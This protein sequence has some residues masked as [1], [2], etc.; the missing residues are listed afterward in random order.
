MQA[1]VGLIAIALAIWLLVK[2]VTLLVQ[3]VVAALSFLLSSVVISGDSLSHAFSWLGV[4]DPA[5]GWLLLGALSGALIGVAIGMRRAGRAYT[6]TRIGTVGAS[7]AGVLLL[8]GNFPRSNTPPPASA[9]TV[10]PPARAR[11]SSERFARVVAS[12]ALI[13]I[14]PNSNRM[15]A[16]LPLNTVLNVDSVA[17]SGDWYFVSAGT[18][19]RG[20]VSRSDI[21]SLVPRLALLPSPFGF[22]PLAS[23][24]SGRSIPAPVAQPM[25]SVV[26]TPAAT[27]GVSSGTIAVVPPSGDTAGERVTALALAKQS[28]NEAWKSAAAFVDAGETDGYMNAVAVLRQLLDNGIS[29][30]ERKYG[31]DAGTPQLRVETSRRIAD[32]IVSCEA[33][34]RANRVRGKAVVPCP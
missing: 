12:Q 5:I 28:A 15:L 17:A 7:V 10:S 3:W 31:V 26:T 21:S 24:D 9:V 1:I 14:A 18:R 2:L 6:R 20:W 19:G 29:Q 11:N 25:D 4:T 32:L 27:V 22:G 16:S 23:S 13:H 34:N 30:F 33:E 8:G